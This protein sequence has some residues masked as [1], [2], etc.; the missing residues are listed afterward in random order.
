METSCVFRLLLFYIG[1]HGYHIRPLGGIL[2][3]NE[4][5]ERLCGLENNQSLNPESG[6]Q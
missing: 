2:Y 1:V 3:I 4:A 5:T 6:E